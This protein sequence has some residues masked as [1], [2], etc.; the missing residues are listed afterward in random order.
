MIVLTGVTGKL[1]GLVARR[2]LEQGADVSISVRDP[3]LVCDW[4]VRVRRGDYA[5]P[6]SLGAA[7]EGA[8]QV[9]LVSSNSSGLH[10]QQHH[11]NAI[12]AARQ[13]GARRLVYTS[14]MGVGAESLFPPMR[15]HAGSEAFLRGGDYLSLRNGFYADSAVQMMGKAWETGK[16]VAPE[17]GP[18]SWTAHLDLAEAAVLALTGRTDWQGASPALTG[19]EALTLADLATLAAGLSGRDIERVVVSDEEYRASLLGRGLPPERADLMVGLFAAS[20]RGEF[21]A[22]DPALEQLLG[23]KPTTMREVLEEALRG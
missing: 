12:E 19:S 4:N 9:F 21:A 20:R 10:A 5:D 11:R 17:D 1:G 3:Q 15:D 8:D 7:F 18:V 22:V 23:R 2:L 13:A 14:H 6:A 16:L